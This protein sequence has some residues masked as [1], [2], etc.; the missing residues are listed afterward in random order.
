MLFSIFLSLPVIICYLFNLRKTRKRYVDR[1]IKSWA[2]SLIFIAGGEVRVK[3]LHNIPSVENICY[4][5]NHQGSFDIPLILGFLPGPIGFIAKKELRTLPIVNLWMKAIGCIFIDRLDKRSAVDAIRQGVK[6]LQSGQPMIIFPEGTRSKS[7]TLGS[8][9]PGSLKL[10]LRAKA[11]IIPISI[12]GSYK[13]L[14]EKR[15]IS[16]GKITMTV[17]TPLESSQYEGDDTSQ[18][19]KK[20]HET[21]DQTL[22]SV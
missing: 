4:I 6:S 17:H 3:G 22:R 19:C 18:I 5:A 8:F 11:T 16:P 9:K 12:S 1:V 20:I 2:R 10:P 15:H 7:A 14:E 13:L 21:I